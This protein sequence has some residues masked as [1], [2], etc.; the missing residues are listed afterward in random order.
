MCLVLS[1][2]LEL[3]PELNVGILFRGNLGRVGALTSVLQCVIREEI[4]QYLLDE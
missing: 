3:F 4:V 2:H 1:D